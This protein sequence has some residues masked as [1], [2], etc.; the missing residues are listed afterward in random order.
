MVIF[1]IQG[2]RI[3]PGLHTIGKFSLSTEGNVNDLDICL[4]DVTVG[5]PDAMPLLFEVNLEMDCTSHPSIVTIGSLQ[6]NLSTLFFFLSHDASYGQVE[7]DLPEMPEM[8]VASTQVSI[9]VSNVD[10]F[11]DVVIKM[12]SITPISDFRV[13]S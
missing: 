7:C 10:K 3:D 6:S 12:T 11:C 8:P 4:S 1:S 5:D 2:A 9:S 13:R